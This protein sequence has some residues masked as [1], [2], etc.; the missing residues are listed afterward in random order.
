MMFQPKFG[1][2]AAG[3]VARMTS[4]SSQAPWPTSPI[5]RSPVARSN[6]KRH[7]LRRP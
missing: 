3:S 5:H 1:A 4:T 7:G 2:A 6:E